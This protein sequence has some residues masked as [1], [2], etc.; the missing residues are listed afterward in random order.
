MDWLQQHQFVLSANLH[1]GSIV[2][3]YPYDNYKSRTLLPCQIGCYSPLVPVVRGEVAMVT[4]I[5]SLSFLS[6][7][8]FSPTVFSINSLQLLLTFA[9]VLH[10]PPNL[11]LSL[12]TQSSHHILGLLRLLFPSTFWASALFANFLSPILSTCPA[13]FSPLLTS[14]FLKLSFTPTCSLSSSSLLLST[15][16]SP[17]ILL[18]QL[19]SQTCTFCCFSVGAIVSKPCM[20]G[21]T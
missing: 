3:N 7:P 17:T 13:H 16:F 4:V 18:M 12:L 15:L 1:G 8:H 2:A 20:P 19:F 14:F 11:S 6:S 5:F 10:S 9:V 21:N